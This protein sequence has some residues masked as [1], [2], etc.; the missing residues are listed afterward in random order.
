MLMDMK[1][2][3]PLLV[4]CGPTG[5]GK[6]SLALSL[7]EKY[8]LEIISADSRQVYRGMDIGTA[9]ATPAER[10]VVPHHMIDLIDPSQEFSV[11]EF[12][13]LA[14]PLIELISA[15][16]NVPCI[17][18]GTGLYIKALVGGLAAL[19][20]GDEN[21]RTQLHQREKEE[22]PGSLFRELQKVDP[23]TA[24]QLHP[25]N[26]IRIV[27]ALEVF[28]LSGEKLSVLKADH[29]FAD[30]CY[31][32]LQLAPLWS[33]EELYRR[34]DL[35]TQEMLKQGFVAEVMNLLER[36]PAE[37]KAFQTLGYR[38]VIRYL[39][40][41]ISAD[42]MLGDIQKFTRQYA[43][44][45]LT[46]FRKEAEIIWVDSSTESGKVIQ[47]IDNFILRQRSGYA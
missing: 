44:R 46:W 2:K 5:S 16:G 23:V 34:I 18:G 26:I 14:R 3:L 6:T 17:V 11:A 19:P 40:N 10:A 7:A 33:R 22:G 25:H 4:I 24:S 45:Q 9:K 28:I 39:K 47:S 30:C 36:Y 12:V 20:T 38:E 21:L 42:Q 35:R 29:R 15:R 43:K 41:E 31:A 8:P 13:D 32:T 1:K 37:L 27:R